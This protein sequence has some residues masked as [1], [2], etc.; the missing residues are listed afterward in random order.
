MWLLSFTVRSGA[1]AIGECIDG[2]LAAACPLGIAPS[3]NMRMACSTLSSCTA[4]AASH[5]LGSTCV[6][7]YA[8]DRETDTETDTET[9]AETD[10]ETDT[11]MCFSLT[12]AYQNKSVTH[13]RLRRC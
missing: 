8:V 5:A 1:I 2:L 12:T 9:D 10:T 11:H 4:L 7:L 3:K 6:G 13:Q